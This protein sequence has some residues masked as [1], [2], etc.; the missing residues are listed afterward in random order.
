MA[1]WDAA[2]KS[3]ANVAAS[4]LG[5]PLP[6]AQ[7]AVAEMVAAVDT[8]LK[9]WA[10]AKCMIAS[11]RDHLEKLVNNNKIDEKH[12][13]G[14]FTAARAGAAH[15]GLTRD[16]FAAVGFDGKLAADRIIESARQDYGHRRAKRIRGH[17]DQTQD[18]RDWSADDFTGLVRLALV[19]LYGQIEAR[20]R[21]DDPTLTACFLA[22][23]AQIDVTARRVR[24]ASM[25]AAIVRDELTCTAGRD[26][27]AEYLGGQAE[28]YNQ[29]IWDRSGTRASALEQRLTVVQ[30]PS[31]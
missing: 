23:H 19:E 6:A 29:T 21:A 30:E 20:L 15:Y 26:L 27:V 14:V 7:V 8:R 4:A 5:G 31:R 2:A 22:L 12:A 28:Q 9:K 25:D 11:R 18:W 16:A 13:A 24:Q 17:P 1:G 3:L 10:E